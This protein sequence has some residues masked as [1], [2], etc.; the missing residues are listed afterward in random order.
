[1]LS[2]ATKRHPVF[3][4]AKID[5]QVCLLIF[6]NKINQFKPNEKILISVIF[7]QSVLESLEHDEKK[8]PT[9]SYVHQFNSIKMIVF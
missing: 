6:Q 2:H 8:T 9:G 1:M 7:L 5:I 3:K 4:K